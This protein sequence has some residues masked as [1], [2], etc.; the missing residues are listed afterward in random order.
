[1]HHQGDVVGGQYVRATI[2][3]NRKGELALSLGLRKMPSLTDETVASWEEVLPGHTGA[4]ATAVGMVGGVVARAALPRVIGRAASAAVDSI[5]DLASAGHTVRIDW[6]DG[7]QSL[8]KLPDKLFQHLAILLRD[9]RIAGDEATG[10]DHEP[11]TPADSPGLG[12][13]LATSLLNRPPDVTKEIAQLARLRDQGVLT[14]D[15][16][17]AKKTELLGRI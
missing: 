7:N 9:R 5:A 10:T 3:I 16:F 15:E 17:T 13:Q 14:E 4:V 8:V 12:A 1:M 11:G 6:V 2:D